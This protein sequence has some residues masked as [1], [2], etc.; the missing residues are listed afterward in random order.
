MPKNLNSDL[1]QVK[2]P[3]TGLQN[4]RKYIIRIHKCNKCGTM[5]TTILFDDFT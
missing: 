1:N 5:Y 4:I 2:N 3:N